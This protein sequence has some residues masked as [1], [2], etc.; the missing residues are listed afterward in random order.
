M[1][2]KRNKPTEQAN[3]TRAENF[4]VLDLRH[5]KANTYQSRNQGVIG[6]LNAVGFGL[7][8]RLKGHEDKEPLWEMLCSDKPELWSLV[9]SLI[10]E[11][12]PEIK[13]LADSIAGRTQL[14]NI[15]V[16][17]LDDGTFDVAYGMRRCL[18]RAY[19]YARSFGDLPLTVKAEIARDI[20]DPTDTHFRSVEEDRGR[21]E[22]TLIDEAK[23]MQFMKRQGLTIPQIADRLATNRQNVHNRLQLLRLTPEEQRRVHTGRLGLVNALKLLK[24]REGDEAPL[25]GAAND[26]PTH[27]KLLPSVTQA[28]AL[29]TKVEKPADMPEEEWALWISP[30]VRRFL[31]LHLGVEF[32]TFKDMVKAKNGR[33]GSKGRERRISRPFSL[34]HR[35]RANASRNAGGLCRAKFVTVGNLEED[36]RNYQR[37]DRTPL[38]HRGPERRIVPSRRLLPACGLGRC[39][40]CSTELTGGRRRLRSVA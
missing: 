32:T 36:K 19:N 7:F 18:A 8:E 14:H 34:V 28:E 15:G 16:T 13:E 31:A 37:M 3:Q 21:E 39:A 11:H 22:E 5:I 29:Y 2:R 17:Q 25:E 38:R 12:E 27:Q 1:A 35:T 20:A 6:N 33:G 4:F 23:R 24:R 40:A 30:D 10:D 9:V 26:S